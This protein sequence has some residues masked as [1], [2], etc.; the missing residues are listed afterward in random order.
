MRPIS[1]STALAI[2]HLQAITF[3][4]MASAQRT[5]LPCSAFWAFSRHLAPGCFFRTAF[6]PVLT[7]AYRAH[8]TS[9][10]LPAVF[11]SAP[12][13]LDQETPAPFAGFTRDGPHPAISYVLV[14]G[15]CTGSGRHGRWPWTCPR[16]VGRAS[17]RQ[18]ATRHRGTGRSSR[19]NGP[20]RRPSG[21]AHV[22]SVGRVGADEPGHLP[23]REVSWLAVS[24]WCGWWLALR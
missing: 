16:L 15:Q 22:L 2:C 21:N 23:L 18:H 4:R 17:T 8:C 14:H 9:R 6:R 5:A 20:R 24:A 19:A 1:K 12:V 13:D 11:R 3:F 10:Q 7:Q